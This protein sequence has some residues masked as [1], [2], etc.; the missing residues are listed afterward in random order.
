MTNSNADFVPVGCAN[1]YNPDD[2]RCNKCVDFLNT[3]RT[4]WA[5]ED[6]SCT[7]CGDEWKTRTAAP[8]ESF[9]DIQQRRRAESMRERSRSAF[10]LVFS[11]PAA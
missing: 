11:H 1:G 4:I 9:E 6:F 2:L 8:V 7:Y 3:G 10:A 5:G